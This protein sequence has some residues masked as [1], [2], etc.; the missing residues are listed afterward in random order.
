MLSQACSVWRTCIRTLPQLLLHLLL[1]LSK[2]LFP[3]LLS[4]QHLLQYDIVDILSEES[5]FAFS[6]CSSGSLE[7]SKQ[8]KS[9]SVHR[10]RQAQAI[11]CILNYFKNT[12]KQGTVL[13]H[14]TLHL[15]PAVNGLKAATIKRQKRLCPLLLRL[16]SSSP[17]LPTELVRPCPAHR[18][19]HS[20]FSCPDALESSALELLHWSEDSSI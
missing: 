3:T 13:Y 6:L 8:H 10:Y 16:L 12:V 14:Q 19:S 11:K 5:L 15:L 17:T 9:S 2:M 4:W 7:I 20:G 1:N 18:P